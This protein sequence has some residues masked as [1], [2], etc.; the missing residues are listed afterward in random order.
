[1]AKSK[2]VSGK[3]IERRAFLKSSLIGSV[4]LASFPSFLSLNKKELKYLLDLNIAAKL[5]DGEKCWCHPRAGIIP[6][7]GENAN[8]QVVMTMNVLDLVGRDVFRGMFGLI[9]NN[10]GKSW[11]DPA[12]LQTLAPRFEIIKGINRPVAAIYF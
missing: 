4:S 1:M 12:E 7:M 11:T 8:P 6:G 2:V 3:P 9:T 5:F 10:L